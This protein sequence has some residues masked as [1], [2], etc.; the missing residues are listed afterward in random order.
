MRHKKSYMIVAVLLLLIAAAVPP[1]VIW[2][3]HIFPT[4]EVS[5]LYSRYEN[6][7]GVEASFV[8]DFRVNDTLFVDVTVLEA[9]TDS[10]WQQ[11][12]DDFNIYIM[13]PEEIALYGDA[14]YTNISATMRPCYD[15]KGTPDTNKSLNDVVSVYHPRHQ[16]CVFH[17]SITAGQFDVVFF[18]VQNSVNN[19]NI[20]FKN[21]EKNR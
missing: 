18:I 17:T 2:W 6:V 3:H 1:L 20:K 4:K 5:E 8:K 9:T 7:D 19:S 12:L 14:Q 11:L 15:Y 10:A 16:I 21:N 13:T